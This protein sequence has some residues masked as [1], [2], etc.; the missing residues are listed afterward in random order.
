MCRAGNDQAE[1][2]GHPVA[3]PGAACLGL[4]PLPLSRSTS[5]L[6][7]QPEGRSYP[8]EEEIRAC[9]GCSVANEPEQV[10]VSVWQG[11]SPATGALAGGMAN[12]S[13]PGRRSAKAD[14]PRSAVP[15]AS[16]GACGGEGR[17]QNKILIFNQQLKL[18]LRRTLTLP[19]RQQSGEFRYGP[20]MGLE[21]LRPVL[22]VCL[23]DQLSMGVPMPKDLLQI[24]EQVLG[25]G[26]VEGLLSHP[27][28]QGNLLRHVPFAFGDVPVNS[29]KYFASVQCLRHGGMPSWGPMPA[30]C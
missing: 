6:W 23:Q 17:G 20:C 9:L 3:D 25:Q 16:G 13:R 2:S 5:H 30:C 28:D 19:Y 12:P 29:G 24:T 14:D 21:I 26:R 7:P 27:L 15:D 18:T 4:E 11:P 8:N 10:S 22:R 1:A